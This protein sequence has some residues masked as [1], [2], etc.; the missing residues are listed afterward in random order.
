MARVNKSEA[1]RIAKVS[2]TTI[3]RY[4]REGKLSATG[5]KIDTSEL[6][7]VFADQG[8]TG[9][10]VTA[11][12][13]SGQ[14]ATPPNVQVLNTRIDALERENRDLRDDRDQWRSRFDGTMDALRAEQQTTQRLLTDQRP[15]SGSDAW[16]WMMAAAMTGIV[17]VAAFMFWSSA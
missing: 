10:T 11:L 7:R 12:R 4:I 1:A 8:V 2:R 14:G 17:A 13:P 5:G 6:H 16:R 3:H 15:R 9:G